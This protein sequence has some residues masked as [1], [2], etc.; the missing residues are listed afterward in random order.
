MRRDITQKEF[1]TRKVGERTLMTPAPLW[2]VVLF[3]VA[4]AAF[5][6]IVFLF[7]AK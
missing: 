4:G 6:A 3:C 2:Q 7:G 5:L 1:W